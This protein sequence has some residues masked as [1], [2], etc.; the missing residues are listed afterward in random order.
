MKYLIIIYITYACKFVICFINKILYFDIIITFRDK[1]KH[2]VL[3][4][5]LRFS[6]DDLKTM[7]NE[8]T[9]LLTNEY[10]KYFFAFEKTKVRYFLYLRKSIFQQIMIYVAH[11]TIKMI[12]SQYQKMINQLTIFSVCSNSFIIFIEL[13]C[14]HKIQKKMYNER[15]LLFEDVYFY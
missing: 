12:F 11:L 4:R 1:N 5:Q 10:Q 14:F 8:I 2:V 13:S 3:K 9:L 7:I 15:N 6:F